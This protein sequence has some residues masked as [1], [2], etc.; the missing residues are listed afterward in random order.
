MIKYWSK[1]KKM[2]NNEPHIQWSVKSLQAAA[3]L[4]CVFAVF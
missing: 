2:E 4:L 3:A 1:K